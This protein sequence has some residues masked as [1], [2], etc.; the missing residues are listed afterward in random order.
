[1]CNHYV[2]H[3][4]ILYSGGELAG[5]TMLKF[6]S[7]IISQQPL[8][9]RMSSD[10]I[11]HHSLALKL[12]LDRIEQ[13][14]R[15]LEESVHRAAQRSMSLRTF[16]ETTNHKLDGSDPS[17]KRPL[18]VNQH[19][20]SYENVMSNNNQNSLNCNS[21]LGRSM[22]TLIQ[23]KLCV[24]GEVY[25]SYENVPH[26]SISSISISSSVSR[27]SSTSIR[28]K[29]KTE[30]EFGKENILLNRLPIR[31]S[32]GESDRKRIKSSLPSLALTHIPTENY[33]TEK[34]IKE[35]P[36]ENSLVFKNSGVKHMERLLAPSELEQKIIEK[37]KSCESEKTDPSLENTLDISEA[38]QIRST[39][40][41]PGLV[42]KLVNKRLLHEISK[43]KT[44]QNILP[45]QS[46]F[47]KGTNTSSPQTSLELKDLRICQPHESEKQ[48][49]EPIRLPLLNPTGNCINTHIKSSLASTEFVSKVLKDSSSNDSCKE[50]I[51]GHVESSLTTKGLV[52]KTVENFQYNDRPKENTKQSQTHL[53]NSV[54]GSIQGDV[55]SP[56]ILTPLIQKT[57]KSINSQEN[58][59]ENIE[60]KPL[61]IVFDSSDISLRKKLF[62]STKLIQN[63]F[64]KSQSEE[65]VD[66]KS[67]QNS[68]FAKILIKELENDQTQLKKNENNESNLPSTVRKLNLVNGNKPVNDKQVFESKLNAFLTV[69]QEPNLKSPKETPSKTRLAASYFEQLAKDNKT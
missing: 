68:V 15:T 32:D 3:E 46:F 2:Q 10:R 67:K 34:K 58:I 38:R 55:Q 33:H 30:H 11:N 39:L 53:K 28:L 5:K 57:S 27:N 51:Q 4:L 65:N 23:N 1:M 43:E 25:Q 69:N 17:S 20:K 47:N 61:T 29:Q 36:E 54:D 52:Q 21:P 35:N 19:H 41:S 22:G 64:K 42:H 13:N 7:P 63:S 18:G 44:E 62:V 26:S 24:R 49:I 37:F 66:P 56:F 48:N 9:P 8:S 31:N 40:P 12:S 60:E 50:N 6:P 59:K 16:R 45:T 14:P